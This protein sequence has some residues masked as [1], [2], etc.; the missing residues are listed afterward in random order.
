MK[1]K[2]YSSNSRRGKPNKT[3]GHRSAPR[4]DSIK[5]VR[6]RGKKQTARYRRSLPGATVIFLG[7]VQVTFESI[8]PFA[9]QPLQ[10]GAGS[11]AVLG[12][13][14]TCDQPDR[15]REHSRIV[16]EAKDRQHVRNEIERQ[17]EI[18]NGAE[19]RHLHLSRRL[20]V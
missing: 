7:R 2:R 5:S 1:R 12:R 19:Q 3:P 8:S 4:N 6:A 16:G 15:G 9:P 10:R 18:G 20:P 17:D 13:D 11:V 14:V